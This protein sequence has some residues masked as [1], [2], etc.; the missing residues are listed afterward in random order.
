MR[1][2]SKSIYLNLY[3]KLNHNKNHSPPRIVI[4]IQQQLLRVVSTD[5][6][7]GMLPGVPGSAICVQ[8]FDDSLYSAIRITYRISLRSSSLRE[9]RYPLLKVV[10]HW[11]VIYN[12][13]EATTTQQARRRLDTTS[14]RF[15]IWRWFFKRGVN[16]RGSRQTRPH[17]YSSQSTISW[18]G[19][20]MILPQVHLRK[21]CYDFTFL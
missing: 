4:V 2:Y 5:T 10:S 15:K 14:D 20:V 1:F 11:Y 12:A 19:V 13:A 3:W 16:V 7:T 18:I 17:R 21:P 6:E 8:K 9:P